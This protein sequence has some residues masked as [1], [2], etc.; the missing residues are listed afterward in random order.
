MIRTSL[1]IL[2]L[3]L[4][5]CASA[6]KQ[7][8]LTEATSSKCHYIYE[9]SRNLASDEQLDKISELYEKSC[10]REVIALGNFVR[11]HRRD[12]FYNV[13]AEVGELFTPEGT[14]T[15]Y[16][17][18]SYER[19]YLSLLISLSALQTKQQDLALVELRRSYNEQQAE[20]YN[21]GYDPVVTLLQASLWDRF[22]PMI[23]RP[24]WKNLSEDPSLN[25]Q[26]VQFAKARI[27]TI[28][29]QPKGAPLQWKIYGVGK[30]ADFDWSYKPFQ[31]TAGPYEIRS[32][33]DPVSSCSSSKEVLLPTS[34]WNKK[35]ASKHRYDYHPLIYTKNLFRLPVGLTYG[36][37]GVSSS[38]AVGAAG[39]GVAG[40][41]SNGSNNSGTAELCVA[42]M[43]AAG[44]LIGKSTD[45]TSYVL[46]PDMRRWKSLPAAIYLT[47]EDSHLPGKCLDSAGIAASSAVLVH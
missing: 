13:S 3:G 5:G 6:P 7:K 40:A 45:L 43:K 14:F 31:K 33:G 15:D 41:L 39:C 30:M 19:V 35:I 32:K 11:E 2:L 8:H 44:Y 1:W 36:L 29:T 46:K 21:Y 4:C 37:V 10:F 28:D 12:K 17:L 47:Q 26:I 24:L 38:L 42:A 27:E 18:E 9:T 34:S 23:A 22:D 16:T 25:E 20:L